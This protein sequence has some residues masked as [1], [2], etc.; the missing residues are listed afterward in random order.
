MSAD[1]RSTS[2][3]PT[4][5]VVMTEIGSTVALLSGALQTG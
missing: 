5:I 1:R 2:F 3:N 4:L